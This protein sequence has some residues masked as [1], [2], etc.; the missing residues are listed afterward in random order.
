MFIGGRR[1]TSVEALGRFFDAIGA[2]SQPRRESADG[3][4]AKQKRIEAA[5]RRCQELGID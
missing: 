1:M 4:P 3:P 2:A 5:E